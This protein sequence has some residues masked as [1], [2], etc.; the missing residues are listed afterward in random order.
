[1]LPTDLR[2]RGYGCGAS[3]ELKVPHRR[4][5][6]LGLTDLDNDASALR[7]MP[8]GQHGDIWSDDFMSLHTAKGTKL[9]AFTVI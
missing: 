3:T 6:A 5:K 9:R 8:C 7:A 4:K 2:G 1:M